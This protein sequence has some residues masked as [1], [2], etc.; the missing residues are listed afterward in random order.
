MQFKNVNHTPTPAQVRMYAHWLTCADYVQTMRGNKRVIIVCDGDS[1]DGRHHNS[2][3]IITYDPEEQREIHAELMDIF[4]RNCTFDRINDDRLYYVKGTE[5]HVNDQE[6]EIG[7]DLGA[8]LTPQGLGAFDVLDM[9]IN[10]RYLKFLHHGKG[11]GNGPNEGNALRNWLRDLYADSSK[12]GRRCPDL[13]VTGHTHAAAYGDYCVM[14]GSNI[15]IV[16]GVICP[17]WQAKTRFAL[18]KVPT[19][20]NSIGAA[21]ITITESGDILTP[22]FLT[23]ETEDAEL[24][25][26]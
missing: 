23:M 25:T 20:V 11:R 6:D 19:A 15:R 8:E 13:V 26:A 17:S 21:F 2:T 9:D 1:V 18:E 4:L 12:A 24:I 5:V 3:Q 14:E 7:R 16:H 10:G 22:V